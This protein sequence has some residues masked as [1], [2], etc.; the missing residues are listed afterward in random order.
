MD[1]D[2]LFML[3]Q[4]HTRGIT[5]AATNESSNQ[6]RRRSQERVNAS[7]LSSSLKKQPTV[8]GIT[9]GK[10]CLESRFSTQSR[11]AIAFRIP[12]TFIGHSRFHCT[13]GFFLTCIESSLNLLLGWDEDRA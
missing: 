5:T 1:F 9:S 6:T 8:E 7:S 11:G 12:P 4:L 3:T 10:Q 13:I 2:F